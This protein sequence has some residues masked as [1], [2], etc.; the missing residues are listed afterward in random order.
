MVSFCRLFAGICVFASVL[1]VSV[2][3]APA[4]SEAEIKERIS[5]FITEVQEQAGEY[6]KYEALFPPNTELISVEAQ[7]NQLTFLFNRYL[8]YRVWLPGQA[9][10]LRDAI[11]SKLPADV[12]ANV[13]VQI[14]IRY[15]QDGKN[16]DYDLATHVTS[17]SQ[18]REREEGR[19]APPPSL[20]HPIVQRPDSPAPTKPTQGLLN[21]NIVVGPSHGY[22]WHKENRWQYQ[23]AR[24]YTIVEDLF[25]LAY[26]NTFLMPMLE[27]AGAVVWPVRERDYQWGE[28]IVDNDGTTR[29]SSFE[30]T[31]SWET[32][33][34]KG[35][36][37][38]RPAYLSQETE[39]FTLGSTIRA[40]A[41]SA[42]DPSSSTAVYTP[43]IPHEGE[44]AVYL[45][46][47][48][49]PRHSS[50]V[51]VEIRH[52]GGTTT[53]RVNQKAGG[54]TWVHLGFFNFAKGADAAKGS[55]RV[56]SAGAEMN[57]EG[58][59]YV[60]ADAVRFGGGT[61]NI[62]PMDQI[63]RKPR[64]HEAS[65]YWLQYAGAPK[66]P[67]YMRD[68][69]D[70]RFGVDY[71]RDIVA[72]SE[73]VNYLVGGPSG[74][75][76]HDGSNYRDMPGLGVPID[77]YLSFHTDAGF[78]EEGLI[79]TLLI[80]TLFD[81]IGNTEFPDGR[82][83]WL[84]RDL[85]VLLQEEV[86]RSARE[87]YSSSFHRRHMWERNLGEIRRPNVPSALIE[88]VSHHNFN[89]MKYGIDPRFQR[90][91]SRAMYKAILRFI[92]YSNGYDPVVMPL[93][94][95]HL[96]ARS[97]GQGDAVLSWR[98][99]LDPLEPTADPQGYI[100]YTSTDGRS[101]DNGTYTSMPRHNLEGLEPD[102]N[103]Y[104]RVSA[105]N[106]GGESLPSTVVGLRWSEEKDPI[107]VVDGFDRISGPAIVHNKQTHG[108]DRLRDRG[109]YYQY[110]YALVGNQYD[111]DPKHRWEN[112]LESP[113]MGGSQNLRED[114]LE[115][116]NTFDHIVTHGAAFSESGVP[117]DSATADAFAA[118]GTV[119][120]YKMINW[121]SGKQRTVLPFPGMRGNGRPDQMEPEFPVL[122]DDSLQRLTSYLKE[123]GKLIMSG[124]YIGED[125]IDGPQ[126]TGYSQDFARTYL[127][128]RHYLPDSTKVNFVE[129]SNGDHSFAEGQPFYVGR[130]LEPPHN[131]LPTVYN[132]ESLE[133]YLPA[134][135]ARPVMI[136]GDS[137]LNA[138]IAT[139][140]VVLMGFPVEA[141]LPPERRA[142]VLKSAIDH[143]TGGGE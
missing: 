35:W 21:R 107:L 71:W 63:S 3:V 141:M 86:M 96:S 132:A 80:Y 22:T 13:Q 99:Q 113:G 127:G 83:R 60:A 74:P 81:D 95:T 59:A 68:F 125:L 142:A 72:R 123:G 25:P 23:R 91:M 139:E 29:H 92:A 2:Q 114:F 36:K 55:V 110:N 30:T 9:N 131:I 76:P 44:Y 121:I 85:S 134:D 53:V 137:R 49:D 38:G 78:D 6:E 94:P 84:N 20:E 88:L 11:K 101:F 98:P 100:V 126:A 64:Y 106:K 102:K 65:T 15:R 73:W 39:P 62:A 43:Y 115:K 12:P 41:T 45:S 108:F 128:V 58:P 122:S 31:G 17:A 105:V 90:D 33:E 1:F 19:Q 143:L 70:V 87:Q 27:N 32:A 138:A 112:D 109:V 75:N 133:A 52:L 82:S 34:Q 104:F 5:N 46:W 130:D 77:L 66:K 69:G 67:V 120:D 26:C 28:V 4:A 119:D 124:A 8:G 16:H 118:G 93:Q 42:N 47:P 61:G 50:S 140:Q 129:I 111:F 24:V 116:G 48:Q 117:F 51:P 103:Y 14:L 97:Q 79:G 136:Y 57:A 54:G 18:I 40:A 10:Y 37:A 135:H 56:S 89:D 7:T